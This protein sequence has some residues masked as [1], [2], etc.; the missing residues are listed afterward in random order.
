M[1]SGVVADV[2]SSVKI[3]NAAKRTL[4]RLLWVTSSRSTVYHLTVK[5]ESQA[6]HQ[7]NRLPPLWN[8][9]N[10]ETL[11]AS[12][13]L[14]SSCLQGLSSHPRPANSTNNAEPWPRHKCDTVLPTTALK[15][16]VSMGNAL[17]W[18]LS[19]TFRLRRF[20]TL[21]NSTTNIRRLGR[22]RILMD[23]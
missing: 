20:S 13:L 14:G 3:E 17:S 11:R 16:G 19:R 23:R 22:Q 21:D 8:R 5:R 1:L 15:N 10:S 12:R 9:L 2:I 6:T 18:N 4:N 7:I